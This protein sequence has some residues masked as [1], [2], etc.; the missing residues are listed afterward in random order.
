MDQDALLH[1]IALGEDGMRQFKVNIDSPD[2]L[3]A[4][5]VAF[6][7]AEGGTIFIGVADDGSIPGLTF[8]NVSR[9]NEMIGNVASQQVRS[10]VTVSTKNVA[11]ANGRI[12][13]VLEIPKGVDKP[14][15]D[16]NSVIWLKVG[17]DKRKINSNEELR[18]MFQMSGQFHGDELPTKAGIDKLDT[19]R[20]REFYLDKFDV[21]EKEYPKTES[22]LTRLLQN[23]KLCTD[24]GKLNLAGLLMFAKR[25]EFLAPQFVVKAIRYPG[26]TI[27]ATDYL[28]SE[29]FAG[30]LPRMFDDAMGFVMR[31]LHK[32]QAGRGINAP[33]RPEIPESVFEELLV[34]AIVHRDYLISAPI[35][36]FI[37]DDRIEI[38]SPGHLPN[39]LT[40]EKIRTG[41]SNHRNPVLARFVAK[42]L[43]P[44]RGVGTGIRRALELW[45]RIEF[46]NDYEGSLFTA[47]IRRPSRNEL[48]IISPSIPV[49]TLGRLSDMM[50]QLPNLMIEQIRNK[51]NISITELAYL[52]GTTE[53]NVS[54]ALQQLQK[55]GKLIRR[56][57][58]TNG[59]FWEIVGF[60]S[61]D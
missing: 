53:R 12:V 48:D 7:N 51:N 50:Q 60:T 5:M 16:K 10:P 1:Q 32:L 43:L 26:N 38:I 22:E 59:E 23:M 2:S 61:N 57:T 54:R 58:S 36:L 42:G 46:Q 3:A 21:S 20:F 13:I 9:L 28:D 19:L 49:A 8:Q 11:L 33:G 17:A 47:I 40:V 31:N 56:T 29:D 27:H 25:P 39:N 18:R 41:N 44:F 34:N 24:D 4:E 30:P 6:A 52:I 55:D 35:R 14:Y 15:R 45:P 37:F